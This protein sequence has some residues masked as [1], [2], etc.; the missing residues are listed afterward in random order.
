M[1]MSYLGIL[2]AALAYMVIGMLWYG[3][4]FG[5]LWMKLAGID[6]KSMKKM[7]LSAGQA[8]FFG[9]L[10]ALVMSWVLDKFVM[11]MGVVDLSTAFT[12]AF[13]IWLGFFATTQMGSFLWE[14]KPF[15]LYV[16]NTTHSLVGLIVMA[17]ILSV[18]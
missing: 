5:K 10:T 13:W 6:K 18:L 2:V 4:L 11:I 8:M 15:K 1:G 14:G 3:P 16:L 9:L 17:W 12:A 7:P